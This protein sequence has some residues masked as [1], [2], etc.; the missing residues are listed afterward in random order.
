MS[1]YALVN[2]MSAARGSTRGRVLSVHRTHEAAIRADDK[3]ARQMKAS[4][5]YLPTIIVETSDSLVRVG[6]DI[7]AFGNT[8]V[9]KDSLPPKADPRGPGRKMRPFMVTV[10][11]DTVD[12]LREAGDGNLSLGVRVAAQKLRRKRSSTG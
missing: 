12:R 10:D 7:L 4:G 9:S 5:S 11:A 8:V 6:D 3:L 2:T 1:A